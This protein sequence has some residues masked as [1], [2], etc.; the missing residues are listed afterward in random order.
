MFNEILKKYNGND[1]TNIDLSE[2]GLAELFF[3]ISG[4]FLIYQDDKMYIYDNDDWRYDT[5][6]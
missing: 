2:R 6:G 3:K 1:L 5:K 4:D